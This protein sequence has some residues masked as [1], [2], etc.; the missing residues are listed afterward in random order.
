MKL[1]EREKKSVAKTK[2][3]DGRGPP[4]L[5]DSPTDLAMRSGLHR[6]TIAR[7]LQKGM[8]PEQ[9]IATPALTRKECGQ[10]AAAARWGK[11]NENDKLR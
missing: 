10:R 4:I 9:A 8:T 2:K 1:T 5:S 11:R 3:K 6:S 7:R